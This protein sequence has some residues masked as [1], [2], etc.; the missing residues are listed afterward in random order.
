MPKMKSLFNVDRLVSGKDT[1]IEVSFLQD[2]DFTLRKMNEYLPRYYFKKINLSDYHREDEMTNIV[3]LDELPEECTPDMLYDK[4]KIIYHTNDNNY[5]IG[6]YSDGKPSKKYKPSS[7][8][9]IRQMYYQLTGA[10]L[11]KQ[12]SKT[13]EFLAIC[14]S[15]TDRHKRVQDVLCHMKKYGI[16]CEY[17]DV[18]DYI[19]QN[20]LELEVVSKTDFET[21]VYDPK[22]NIIFLC[23]GILNYKGKI[24]VFE[25]KTESS[26]KFMNR[27]GVD[28][29]HKYQAYTYSLEF[30]INDVLFL[31]ENRDICNK[32][33]Y[34][35]HVTEENK[36]FMLDRISTC[37]QYIELGVTPPKPEDVEKKTC[38]YCEYK[39]QCRVDKS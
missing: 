22:H 37:D 4:N 10:D 7:L 11:D 32:K 2:F 25:C 17:T 14:E 8:H 35:L 6:Y 29:S 34:I 39:T 16:D 1:P 23:D 30:G 28:D 36:Q 15:G 18:E 21:K 5:Y 19:K 3:C 9:C 38:Q 27:T 26:F 20:N 24:F 33:S 13:G 12:S 31:Y